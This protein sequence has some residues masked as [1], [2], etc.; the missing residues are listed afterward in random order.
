M[1]IKTGDRVKLTPEAATK[2]PDL[3][4]Q[5][6]KVEAIDRGFVSIEW[7]GDHGVSWLSDN[8]VEPI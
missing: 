7:D 1:T 8:M 3:T 5:V 6:G 4:F 2:F